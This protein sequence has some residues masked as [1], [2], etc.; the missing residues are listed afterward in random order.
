MANNNEENL[1]RTQRRGQTGQNKPT[2]KKQPQKAPKK[3]LT[4]GKIIW[5]TFATL[6]ILGCLAFLGGVGLFWYYAKDAPKIEDSKLDAAASSTFYA[7][8]TPIADLGAERR[9]K[10]DS[11]DIPQLLEDAIVSVEDR[12]FYK[13]IGVD[14]IRIVGSALSNVT[15]GGMQGGST[16][17]Q[18]L[19]KL[20]FFSTKASDQTLKRK[21][22]EAWMAVQLEKEKSKEEILTYYINKVYMSNGIS[23]MQTA[24]LAYFGKPLKEL[25]L[26]QTALLAGMPQAP[27]SYDPYRHGDV[28]KK[29][30][31]IVLYTMLENKKITQKEYDDAV[32]TP[33]DDGLI[34]F[35]DTRQDWAEYDGYIKEVIAQ[36]KELTGKDVYTD[37]LQ[38]YTN[39]DLDAQKRL[40]EIVNSDQ[41]I[42]Y[43]DDKMQVA[44]TLMDTS[45]GKVIA[46]IGGRNIEKGVVLGNN[47]AV[48]TSRDFG[49]TMKPV[50]DYGPAFE[51]LKD[52]TALRVDDEP[53]TYPGTDIQVRNWDGKYFGN[54][55]LR[56]ALAYS[57]NVPAVKTLDAVGL[58]KA[59]EFLSGLGIDYQTMEYSNAISS[60]TKQDGTKY[61]ASSEKLAAAY[62]AFANGG[63]YYK[64]LYISKIVYQ[65]GSVDEFTPE[66]KR[67][68]SQGTAYMVTD[69]LKDVI[70][71]GTGTN[72][73]IPGLIQAGKTGTSNYTD[74]DLERLGT[75]SGVYPDILFA[76]YTPDYSMA[77]WTGYNDHLTP[78]T[79]QSNMIA[80]AVY[81]ELMAYVT[82]NSTVKDWEMPDDLVRSGGELYFK[83]N[84]VPPVSSVA[85]SSTTQSTTASVTSESSISESS[86][87]ETSSTAASSDK[88][89]SS[90]TSSEVQSTQPVESSEP[91]VTSSEST[92]SSETTTSSEKPATEKK[93]ATNGAGQ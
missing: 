55:S 36:V 45:S 61:G 27:E 29:R 15:S 6:F 40:Y 22:Q 90:E 63:T 87:A 46:Q 28:A 56:T 17:T 66:G 78:V 79:D 30:R 68:M 37:G 14:P 1:S 16:L 88:P 77:V 93:P 82:R 35:E 69:I 92:A 48:N 83:D 43:P 70:T 21:A 41:Y 84:Y 47:L 31:D 23:G 5:R 75:T 60:N 71:E 33:I 80:S 49:S 18:Q 89:A 7:G 65:D 13:H 52:S 91:P 53:Y 62:S 59:K 86:T 39:L 2:K 4:V 8:D 42:Q 11:Q 12:R 76:G 44:A 25:N 50:T 3:K 85:P 38:V 64:P 57:R 24:S 67:A 19:I 58:D 81:R 54:I 34:K 20:S 32:K 10:V 51:Y 26:A 74:E 72:A 73:Q 9:E